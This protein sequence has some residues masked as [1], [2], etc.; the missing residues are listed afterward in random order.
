M[1]SSQ[2]LLTLMLTFKAAASPTV[3]LDKLQ[4]EQNQLQQ[5][6]LLR[7]KIAE[8]I[9]QSLGRYL[10]PRHF[11]VDVVAAKISSPINGT[12]HPYAPGDITQP[13]RSLSAPEIVSRLD[14]LKIN[15]HFS[16]K[17]TPEQHPSIETILDKG[18]GITASKG[19]Q[20]NFKPLELENLNFEN[21][22][23]NEASAYKKAA[24]RSEVRRIRAEEKNKK[25]AEMVTSLSREVDN[26]KADLRDRDNRLRQL[27]DKNET[28]ASK[29]TDLKKLINQLQGREF[30]VK[31]GTYLA[32]IIIFFVSIVMLAYLI[33]KAFKFVG[34]NIGHISGSLESL[35]AA[36]GSAKPTAHASSDIVNSKNLQGNFI[37]FAGFGHLDQINR[38]LSLL[39]SEI[40]DN[41]DNQTEFLFLKHLSHEL[42]Q[43]QSVP[44]AVCSLEI[45]GSEKANNIFNKLEKSQQE[46]IVSFI[47]S[48]IYP[49]GKIG[50]MMAA[51]DS[52]KTKLAAKDFDRIYIERDQQVIDQMRKLQNKD[53][54]DLLCDADKMIMARLYLY[55][56]PT[57]IAEVMT[58]AAKK[59]PDKIDEVMNAVSSIP[60]VEQDTS[61]DKA[62]LESMI[63]KVE[64]LKKDIHGT[65]LDYYYKIAASLDG[66]L[67]ERLIYQISAASEQ[68]REYLDDR[69]ITF[70]TL[71]KLPHALIS[72]VVSRLTDSELA[73][74]SL[75]LEDEEASMFTEAIPEKNQAAIE[76]EME[77]IVG[78]QQHE[79]ISL[80]KSAKNHV[81]EILEENRREG[82]WDTSLFKKRD[83]LE[84]TD[85]A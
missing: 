79:I 53:L 57:Q 26:A 42:S 18:L 30:W 74:L 12:D 25:T 28:R 81:I 7:S 84:S 40:N 39:Q 54:A 46:K 77:K 9:N 38:T 3:G 20:I 14:S 22:F 45:L 27:E 72:G 55:L 15:I 2:L 11:L 56:E 17:V 62:L 1:Q 10:L 21:R 83:N 75:T 49:K 69:I 6:S 60:Q 63:T 80:E 82:R 51:A 70:N 47:A 64:E 41:W 24:T 50:E 71:F 76:V 52:I 34:H 68:I 73:L 36:L 78:K 48:G 31:Y 16:T 8:G 44:N 67:A 59:H 66:E 4:V 13:L 43:P 5:D 32:A 29:I 23:R 61:I 19:H 58:L 85:A 35:G 37:G 33:S 65:Y